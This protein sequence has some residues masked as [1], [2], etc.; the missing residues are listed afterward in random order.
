MTEPAIDLAICM[1]IASSCRDFVVPDECLVFGEVGLSGEIRAV[2]Q[3]EQRVQEARKL[4]FSSVMLPEVC[5]NSIRN[6][7]GIRLVYVS[8]IREA[9]NFFSK[10]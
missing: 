4:G 6:T 3:A 9:V 2:S 8:Q 10:R 5:R 1:A 7:E